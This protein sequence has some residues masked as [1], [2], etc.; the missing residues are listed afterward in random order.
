[1]PFYE[2]I[3]ENGTF[4][5]MCTESDDE[6]IEGVKAHHERAINGEAGGPDG[7]EAVRIKRVLRYERHPD[8]YNKEQ[9]INAKD[10]T[11][12]TKEMD[13]LT[14]PALVDA[15]KDAVHPIVDS[16]PHESNFKMEEDGE[17]APAKWGGE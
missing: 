10:L 17:L 3:Y 6:T 5:V 1:M 13:D 2:V 16:G 9:K 4:S 15:L 7:R 8:D 14:V 12:I 11:A